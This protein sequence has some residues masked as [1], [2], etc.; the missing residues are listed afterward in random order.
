MTPGDVSGWE[1]SYRETCSG[2][3]NNPEWASL[4][5]SHC[6]SRV[7]HTVRGN[8]GRNGKWNVEWRTPANKFNVVGLCRK[9]GVVG[10]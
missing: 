6:R 4:V 8:E 3:V 1:Y 2:G 10:R 7:A 5:N 9:D